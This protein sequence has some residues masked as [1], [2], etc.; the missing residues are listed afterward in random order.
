MSRIALGVGGLGSKTGSR[1]SAHISLYT[2]N[3]TH[4]AIIWATEALLEL[5]S[6]KRK[7]K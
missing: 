6:G 3:R 4:F 2:G 7:H 5:L 1:L